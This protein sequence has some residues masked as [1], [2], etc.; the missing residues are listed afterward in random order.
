MA[1]TYKKLHWTEHSKIKM[2]QYGLSKQ[3]LLGILYRPERKEKG[4]APGT[5][6]VMKTNKTFFKAKQISLTKAWRVPR[7]A[8]GEIWLMYKDVILR[9]GSGQERKIISAW[10]YPGIS[11]PGEEIPIPEDIK[12]ELINGI[13][14]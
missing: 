4:I 3:K 5:L 10:R 14:E 13:M 8:P 9:H 6:A 1:Q 11:K 2:R 7:K 12:R